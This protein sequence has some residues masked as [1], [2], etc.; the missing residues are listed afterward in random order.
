MIDIGTYAF[1]FGFCVM[2]GAIVAIEIAN[3]ADRW[4]KKVVG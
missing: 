4:I 3:L 2:A 1:C